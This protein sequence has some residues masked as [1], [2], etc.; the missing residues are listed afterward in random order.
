M[1]GPTSACSPT[2]LRVHK[3]V[4]FLKVIFAQL[5]SRSIVAAR[6]MRHSLARRQEN[7]YQFENS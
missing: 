1:L 6:L 5:T 7:L 3:I 2:P 4:A